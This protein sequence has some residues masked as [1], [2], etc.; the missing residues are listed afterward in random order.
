MLSKTWVRVLPLALMLVAF[1]VWALVWF[2]PDPGQDTYH[3][4][5]P[6]PRAGSGVPDQ[7]D[8][9]FVALPALAPS[10]GAVI[11]AENSL[12][13]L[14][15][16][17]LV[18]FEYHSFTVYACSSVPRVSDRTAC[19]GQAPFRTVEERGVVTRYSLGSSTAPAQLSA[20]ARRAQE[21]FARV[22][23]RTNPHWVHHYGRSHHGYR[24]AERR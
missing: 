13:P 18:A 16:G 19:S 20:A 23:L 2:H 21:F 11:K 3:Q 24:R 5:L 8:Y 6:R 9:S 1:G 17:Q 22:P 14:R 15:K 10:P 4:A 7:R 12:D